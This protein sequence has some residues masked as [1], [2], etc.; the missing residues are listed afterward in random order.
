MTARFSRRQALQL[1]ASALAAS[2]LLW[3]TH[4]GYAPFPP[5]ALFAQ[6]DGKGPGQVRRLT[7]NR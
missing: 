4:P 6:G 7:E 5:G 2:A 3:L 1:G